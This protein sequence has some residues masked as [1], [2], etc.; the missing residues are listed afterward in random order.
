MS[1]LAAPAAT[2]SR[3]EMRAK[4]VAPPAAIL[5]WETSASSTGRE[6]MV[7]SATSPPATRS[8]SGSIGPYSTTSLCPLARSNCGASRSSTGRELRKVST[9]MSAACAPVAMAQSAPSHAPASRVMIA[10]MVALPFTGWP[11]IN[12]WS[13]SIA[14]S[15]ARAMSAPSRH[16]KYHVFPGD[17]R[18]PAGPHGT[19][20]GP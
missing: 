12:S 11:G 20:K 2:N 14:A 17:F 9:L 5:P 6:V 18:R 8:R 16:R 1:G 10:P 19:I 7:T 15:Q 4:S 3:I 13:S